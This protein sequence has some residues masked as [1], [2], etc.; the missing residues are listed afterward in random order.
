MDDVVKKKHVVGYFNLQ[1]KP[2]SPK[3]W[4]EKIRYALNKEREDFQKD[5]AKPDWNAA[6]AAY[7]AAEKDAWAKCGRS[8]PMPK[9]VDGKVVD[10]SDS[11]ICSD[12]SADEDE[13][14]QGTKSAPV[15]V[16]PEHLEPEGASSDEDQLVIVET[17]GEKRA[18]ESSAGSEGV[19]FDSQIGDAHSCFLIGV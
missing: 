7:K 10:E 16:E 14:K 12:E 5:P 11:D 17:S 2:F 8:S 1:G 4:Y 19:R 13:P 3:Q 6:V 18:A 9:L 15:D